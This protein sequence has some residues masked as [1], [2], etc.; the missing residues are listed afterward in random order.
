MKGEILCDDSEEREI[1]ENVDVNVI[2]LLPIYIL[3]N[4]NVFESGF[5]SCFET[6]FHSIRFL[7]YPFFQR[8]DDALSKV[9]SIR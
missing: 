5:A 2:F 9:K 3:A 4:F 6:S 1:T 7:C 8:S